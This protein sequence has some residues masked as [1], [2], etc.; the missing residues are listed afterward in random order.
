ME[1]LAV[2]V[3]EFICFKDYT[4]PFT[5]DYKILINKIEDNKYNYTITNNISIV[6][7][8]E[9]DFGKVTGFI[10]ENGSGKTSIARLLKLIASNHPPFSV[11]IIV[12]KVNDEIFIRQHFGKRSTFKSIIIEKGESSSLDVNITEINNNRNVFDEF[13]TKLIYYSNLFSYSA[14]DWL[15]YP[16]NKIPSL[17]NLS[18]D[19]TLRKTLSFNRVQERLINSVT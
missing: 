9:K 6:N 11:I 15:D 12:Y 16:S 10:G 4:I 1:L 17:I 7:I 3:E 18:V 8:F 19:Y 13:N 14:D 2:Y 5:P